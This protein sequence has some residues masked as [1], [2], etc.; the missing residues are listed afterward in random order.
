MDRFQIRTP[1]NVMF[2]FVLDQSGKDTMF[3]FITEPNPMARSF[4]YVTPSRLKPKWRRG[5]TL[6]DGGQTRKWRARGV[7][8]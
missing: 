2:E 4:P 5:K 6:Q 7:R 1:P 3:G 8:H